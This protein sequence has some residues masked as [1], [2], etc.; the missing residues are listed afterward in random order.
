MIRYSFWHTLYVYS[1]KEAA[2]IDLIRLVCQVKDIFLEVN[3]CYPTILS[4]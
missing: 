1:T 4:T 2:K 3:I